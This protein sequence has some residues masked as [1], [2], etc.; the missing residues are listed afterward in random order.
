MTCRM[1]GE[2]KMIDWLV[3]LNCCQ[4]VEETQISDI[5][6]SEDIMENVK[7]FQVRL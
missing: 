4:K 1:L 6:K 3:V 7:A 5:L 2:G